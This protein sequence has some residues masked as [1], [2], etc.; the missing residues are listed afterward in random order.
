[1]GHDLKATNSKTF[2]QKP[3][4]SKDEGGMWSV[5]ANFLMSDPLFLRLSYGQV[6]MFLYIS[7]K[8]MLFSVLASFKVQLSLSR[9]LVLAK[10]R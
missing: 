9:V 3:F 6:R 10:R 7:T 2:L 8:Q 5:V 4:Y 1:M